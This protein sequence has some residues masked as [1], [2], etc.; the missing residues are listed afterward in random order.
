MAPLLAAHAD[1]PESETAAG[2][3][4]EA[5]R[6]YADGNFPRAAG[7]LERALELDPAHLPAR[8]WL[9]LALHA[10]GEREAALEHYEAVQAASLRAPADGATD[11]QRAERGLLIRCEALL[12][13][14]LNDERR[15]NGLPLLLPD[16]RL[17]GLARGHS[18]EMRD[19]NYFAHESPTPHRRTIK[20]RFLAVVTGVRSYSIGE[21]IA[22]R[23][24]TGA[25][26]LSPDAVTHTHDEWM[27]SRGHRANILGERFERIGI[28]IAVNANGDYWATQFFARY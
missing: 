11:E 25:Y 3:V 20:D 18:G 15:E 14:L 16:L 7:R 1:E 21:N 13:A 17:S 19:L 22:R 5:R 8:Q 27:K 2:L 26:S 24:A 4:N 12:V 28:G 9:G 6:L 10:A 23:Y